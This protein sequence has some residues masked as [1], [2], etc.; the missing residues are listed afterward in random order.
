MLAAVL[1]VLFTLTLS[2]WVVE[3]FVVLAT[4]LLN[5][6]WLGWGMLFA[7]LWLFAGETR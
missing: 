4:P 1:L 6:S 3:P 2:H 7:L 5:L